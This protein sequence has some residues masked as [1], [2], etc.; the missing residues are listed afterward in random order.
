MHKKKKAHHRPSYH[1]KD[2]EESSTDEE[3]AQW[4][5]VNKIL[6]VVQRDDPTDPF[7]PFS[8]IA[9]SRL[10]EQ[11]PHPLTPQETLL[12]QNYAADL[13]ICTTHDKTDPPSVKTSQISRESKFELGKLPAWMRVFIES[14]FDS[15]HDKYGHHTHLFLRALAKKLEYRKIKNYK[16]L[17]RND[18][19]EHKPNEDVYEEVGE[20]LD[21]ISKKKKKKKKPLV[22]KSKNLDIFEVEDELRKSFKE[23]YKNIFLIDFILFFRN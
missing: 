19:E 22:E 12:L 13:D 18:V 14:R 6:R 7:K 4:I 15:I 23:S 17:T 11:L 9:V 16:L 1:R 20:Y 10:A 5:D 21:K 3:A 2:E 8:F